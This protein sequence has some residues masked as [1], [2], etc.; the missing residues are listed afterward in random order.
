MKSD[1]WY[2]KDDDNDNRSSNMN[3]SGHKNNG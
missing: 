1:K 2:N 3:N